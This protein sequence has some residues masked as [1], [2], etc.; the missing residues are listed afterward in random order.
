MP[1]PEVDAPGSRRWPMA[2]IGPANVLARAVAGAP[3][4]LRTKLL[5]AF[6]SIAALLVVVAVLGLRQ[7]GQSNARVE[8]LGS[9]Q[10]RESQ[11]QILGS[12]ANLLR[13]LLAL[14]SGGGQGYATLTGVTVVPQP[15]E[16]LFVDK[17]L[18]YALSVFSPSTNE[19]TFGFVPPTADER[20]LVRIRSDFRALERALN[21]V[22]TLDGNGVTGGRVR[23]VLLQAVNADQ[24][25]AQTATDL[26]SR[27][28]AETSALI[29]ANA[30]SYTSS[31][32][33]FILVTAASVAF[34]LV[35]GLVLSWS[36]IDPIRRTKTRLAAIA[37]GD[38]SG[39]LDV[40]NRDELGSLAANVN[41]M[42]DELRRL[43]GELQ[44]ASRHKSEFLANMSHELRTPLN[45]I[46]GFSQLLQQ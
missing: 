32:N 36:L 26:A 25:L 4:N 8:R 13:Q 27:T 12:Q 34:A 9:L 42:N 44:T 7:L 45:A 5:I 14:R 39:R 24:D 41:K 22:S 37:A 43:Y 3:A 23:G 40:P 38:F 29:A 6:L 15:D 35:L 1:S 33:L 16:W 2:R 20:L 17:A 30:S 31:R 19:V 28:N 11:Y 21:I 46:P 18:G 10:T